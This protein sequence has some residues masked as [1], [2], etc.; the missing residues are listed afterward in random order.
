MVILPCIFKLFKIEFFIKNY[1]TNKVIMSNISKINLYCQKLKLNAPYFETLKKEG[2]DHHPI[3]RVS[4]TFGKNI[5]MGEGSTLKAAKEEAASKIV[6]LLDI[7]LK[8]K[9]LQN[10]VSYTIDSY[11]APLID[12]WENNH[13]EY[14]LTLKRK[15]KNDVEYKNFKVKI[16]Q[17]LD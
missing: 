5:E 16:I 4:C 6:E 13:D 12:I 11:N 15:E 8:L 17:C 10:N 2:A 1:I 14:I 3:F 9:E 7:D